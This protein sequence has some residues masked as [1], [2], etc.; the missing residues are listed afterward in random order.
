MS[1]SVAWEQQVTIETEVEVC[2]GECGGELSI[3]SAKGA[4]GKVEVDVDL[5]DS[6]KLDLSDLKQELLVARRAIVEADE[7]RMLVNA[8]IGDKLTAAKRAI[9]DVLEKGDM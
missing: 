6:C 1:E 9:D 7:K 8:E 3:A 5:C 2:C 4:E